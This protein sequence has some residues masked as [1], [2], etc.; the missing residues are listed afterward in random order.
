MRSSVAAEPDVQQLDVQKQSQQ[1]TETYNELKK[2]CEKT[3]MMWKFSSTRQEGWLSGID[4]IV[5]N[6]RVGNARRRIRSCSSHLR[7]QIWQ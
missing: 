1:C 7:K 6:L 5:C 3:V 2:L 4:D